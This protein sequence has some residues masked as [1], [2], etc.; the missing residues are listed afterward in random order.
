MSI[1]F[2][3]ATIFKGKDEQSKQFNKM[4]KNA[5]KFGEKTSKAFKKASKS[6]TSFG[7]ITKGILTAGL[8]TK[9]T[10]AATAGISALTKEFISYDAAI[11]TASAKFKGLDL[12]TKKG[13]KTLEALKKTAREVGATTKFSATEGAAGLD[14]YATAGFTAEQ[15]MAVLAPTAKLAT[16]ANLD[17]ART[18]DIA[19][20][21]LGAF[22]L[23]T[24][25]TGQLQK[26][27]TRLSDVMAK[28]MTSTNT[29]ME[30]MFEAIK[31][32]AP[33]FTMAGQSIETFNTLMGTMA[34][35]GVKGSEAGTSLR[36]V[37]LR[38]AKATPEAQDALDALGVVTRDSKGNFRDIIDVLA[39]LEKGLKSKGTAEKAAAISTIFGV[40][41]TTGISII[42]KEGTKNLRKFRE[43]LKGSA[44][45]TDRMANIM[46]SSLENRLL[47][48]KS[49]A[50]ET[51]FQFLSAFKDQ[52]AGAIAILTKAIRS[53]NMQPFINFVK[54][55]AAVIRN[56]VSRFIEVGESSGLFDKIREAVAQIKP[57]FSTLFEIAKI[58]FK[59]LSDV[60]VFDLIAK[61]FGIVLD[62][63]TSVAKLFVDW[64]ET[65]KKAWE[66]IEPFSGAL[67]VLGG[68]FVAYKI[69][70]IAVNTWTA[71]VTAAQTAMNIVMNLNPIGLII[72][73]AVGLAAGAV[74][75][76]QNWDTVVATFKEV[77]QWIKN[78]SDKFTSFASEK[79]GLIADKIIKAWEPIKEFFKAIFT[80]P[81][82]ALAS[83]VDFIIEKF[84]T[85]NKI[86]SPVLGI[87]SK[88]FGMDETQTPAG[89][90]AGLPGATPPRQPPNR[91]QVETKQSVNFKGRLDIAGAPEGSEFTQSPGAQPVDVK[92]LGKPAALGGG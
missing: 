69:I 14:F 32:G 63:I 38:L 46:E 58:V 90:Q 22:G 17:L 88:F 25:D 24:K 55:S 67:A 42:L 2:A 64:R 23:M 1:T 61:G 12:T 62:A 19:S 68:A 9:A 52:G 41:A 66:I 47:S 92:M 59:Q 11:T 36:N 44:G 53:I 91:V 54:K 77:W 79:F 13:Q 3:V 87:V 37:M 8:I 89:N 84:A 80:S 45:E 73:A 26:N 51:G 35:S 60:G 43:Q 40:R 29:N 85:I 57:V 72:T 10:S 56:L 76:W 74:L 20:D 78:L 48:L 86:V 34:S 21:S 82:E 65:I 71:I 15:A 30:D 83:L 75:L 28:T 4:G 6:A 5:K 31:K 18:S 39:D 81:K 33:T 16:V 27:F 7:T 50:I 70:L 49:A